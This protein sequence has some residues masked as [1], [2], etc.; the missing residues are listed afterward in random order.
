MTALKTCISREH[1]SL[2]G[3]EHTSRA[4]CDAFDL[5]SKEQWRLVELGEIHDE[6]GQL[7]NDRVEMR[8]A[9]KQNEMRTA[10]LVRQALARGDSATELARWAGVSRERIYQLR[11]DRR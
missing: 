2:D 1:P 3:V 4:E 8:A 10:N 11:D 6:L 7:Q 9:V 5:E